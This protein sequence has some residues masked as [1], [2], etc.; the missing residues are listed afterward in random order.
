MLW[1]LIAICIMGSIVGFSLLEGQM[2]DEERM[3]KSLKDFVALEP[4]EISGF[5]T[6]GGVTNRY[7]T[8]WNVV[9]IDLYQT[10]RRKGTGVP[11]KDPTDI[12]ITASLLPNRNIAYEAA[13][14]MTTS[15]V[16]YPDGAGMP[17]GSWTGLPIGE[18]SWATAP[19]AEKPA[20][21]V[22][23]ADLV[24]WNDR[25]A[26][27]VIVDY[28]PIDPKAKTAIF[29]P[30]ADEDMQLG[31]LAARLILA[32]ASWVLLG[33]NDLSQLRLVVNGA[34]LP[35]KEYQGNF[36]VPVT[37]TLNRLGGQRGEEVRGFRLFLARAASDLDGRFQG[38]VGRTMAGSEG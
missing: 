28:Q 24:V 33:F 32:K 30:V 16:G 31:E 26:L 2:M 6:R 22:G 9:A 12:S 13:V 37:A 36:F 8:R 29:L 19:N 20:P 11:G 18:K 10:L 35:A 15:Q 3:Q 38:D 17:Q 21:G 34:S 27:G 5:D 4:D 7:K 23:T 14:L 1:L 25:L